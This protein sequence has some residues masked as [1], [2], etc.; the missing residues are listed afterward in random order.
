MYL[1]RD[2]Y[3]ACGEVFDR[4]VAGLGMAQILTAPRSPW[5]NAECLIGSIRRECLG[6][7]MV[8]SE[9][10][11]RRVLATYVAY[12]HRWRRTYRW[13]WMLPIGGQYK[14]PIK[15]PWSRCRK[16]VG[17]ITI[18][19]GEPHNVRHCNFG[20]DTTMSTV[21]RRW[22]RD[23]AEEIADHSTERIGRRL[24]PT[25]YLIALIAVVV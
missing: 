10:H 2:R 19:N 18:M 5:Q 12:Y 17:C 7:V 8:F 13:P 11:L 22:Q 20:R 1:L 25:K 24:G 23:R 9:D 4:R 3:A 21:S 6:H 16:W 14:S 15:E